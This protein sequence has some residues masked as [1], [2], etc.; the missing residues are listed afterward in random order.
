LNK[1]QELYE[2]HIRGIKNLLETCPVEDL[3]AHWEYFM[4]QYQV[5]MEIKDELGREVMKEYITIIR[6]RMNE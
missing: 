6:R 1:N 5:A 4:E 3:D 2:A